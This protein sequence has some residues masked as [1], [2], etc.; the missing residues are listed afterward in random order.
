M[1]GHGNQRLLH[2]PFGLL[3][4]EVAALVIII[5]VPQ[6]IE[7]IVYSGKLIVKCFTLLILHYRVDTCL[8]DLTNTLPLTG[9]FDGLEGFHLFLF[10][11]LLVVIDALTGEVL[12]Q[13]EGRRFALAS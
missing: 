6:V 8:E 10:E 13:F 12:Y 5:N 2:K 7:H 9:F 1:P 11:L 3:F 4:V